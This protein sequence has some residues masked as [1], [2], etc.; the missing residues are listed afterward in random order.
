MLY[1][2]TPC[3]LL[4]LFIYNL[5]NHVTN[6]DNIEL[7]SNNCKLKV[8]QFHHTPWRRLGERKYSS[9]VTSSALD[10]IEWSALRFCC[11]LAPGKGPPVPIVQ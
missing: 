8:K 6:S 2:V 3:I 4:I 7:M 1:N 10:G 11:A 9:Y 5:F